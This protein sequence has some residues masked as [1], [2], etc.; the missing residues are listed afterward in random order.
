MALKDYRYKPRIRAAL[1]LP[2]VILAGLGLKF[3]QG[4]GDDWVNHWGPASVAY[5]WA[6]MLLGFLVLPKSRAIIP[7]AMLVLI[8]TCCVELSQ[9]FDGE[10]LQAARQTWFGRILLGTTYSAWDFPAYLVGSLTGVALLRGCA[11]GQ[12]KGEPRSGENKPDLLS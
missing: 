10:F 1:L 4:P 5:V 12:G 8:G 3:Y 6:F 11:A 7:I 9:R 2:I